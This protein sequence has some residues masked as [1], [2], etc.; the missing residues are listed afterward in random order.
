MTRVPIDADGSM[1]SEPAMTAASSDRMSPNR[2]SVTSTSKPAGHL[3]R[4]IAAESTSRCSSSTS[5]K[6]AWTSS[7]TL[8]H[9][10][11]VARTFAL[12][13]WVT[14]RRRPRASSNASVTMR[15]I[16]ASVYHRVSMAAR[17]S[18]VSRCSYGLPK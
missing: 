11:L 1:P 13:T 9:R 15:R 6:S 17:P 8:R 18:G 3:A 16:S 7:V 14:L 4:V 5:G 10:R 2:F 12:S